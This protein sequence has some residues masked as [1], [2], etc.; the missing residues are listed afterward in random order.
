MEYRVADLEQ[1]AKDS[2]SNLKKTTDTVFQS[3]DKL[4]S[5]LQKLGWELEQQD[6]EEEKT[7]EKL[8]ETCMRYVTIFVSHLINT[9]LSMQI[10]Q[11]DR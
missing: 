6:P 5:S 7:I 9:D 2:R 10:N 11:D 3:D 1:I 4:L 8:R